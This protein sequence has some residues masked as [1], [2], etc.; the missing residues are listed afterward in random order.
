MASI[1]DTNRNYLELL[2]QNYPEYKAGLF[3][4]TPPVA[5]EELFNAPTGPLYDV[6]PTQAQIDMEYTPGGSWFEE[7]D[8]TPTGVSPVG[9]LHNVDINRT[10]DILPQNYQLEDQI[11]QYDDESASQF[12]GPRETTSYAE[13]Q[14][15]PD[16][17]FPE[18]Q[19]A[20]N[21]SLADMRAWGRTPGEPTLNPEG[22]LEPSWINLQENLMNL[23]GTKPTSPRN[24][25][26][27]DAS[28]ASLGWQKPADI[29]KFAAGVLGHEYRHNLL[30]MP[31]FKNIRDEVMGTNI[32]KLFANPKSV[33][34]FPSL[35]NQGIYEA[36]AEQDMSERSK[37]EIF[38]EVLDMYNQYQLEGNMSGILSQ[39]NP[40]WTNAE[41]M[42]HLQ[43]NAFFQYSGKNPNQKFRWGSASK[44]YL[45]QMWPLA[46]KYF[47]EVDR[48]GRMGPVNKAKLKV[49]MPENLSFNTGAGNIPTPKR[50][51]VAPSGVHR[52]EGRPQR[53]SMPTG[54]AGRN[55][56]GYRAKGGLIDIPL[57]GR[58]RDI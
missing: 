37:E 43:K 12:E 36:G 6:Q 39:V 22:E 58:S 18:K 34:Q 1:T 10:L 9:P 19:F 49:G 47:T 4:S 31:G 28:Q 30:E 27:I 2:M 15:N 45:N 5:F 52:G 57:P 7:G 44:D 56:F 21:V 54:T 46:K 48:Q 41:L 32:N 26:L 13:W 24:E 23:V 50:T 20:G 16:F 53:G 51:Y 14:A 25:Q 8:P 38:N 29:N 35:Y 55:P 42:E 3:E 17:K 11:E 33:E 40:E